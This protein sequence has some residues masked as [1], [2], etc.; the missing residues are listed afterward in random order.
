M[1]QNLDPS[2]FIDNYKVIVIYYLLLLWSSFLF[3]WISFA[4]AFYHNKYNWE[5]N[6]TYPQFSEIMNHCL[7]IQRCYCWKQIVASSCRT[8]TCSL[9]FLKSLKTIVF[10]RPNLTTYSPNFFRLMPREVHKSSS[11][12]ECSGCNITVSWLTEINAI[13][14]FQ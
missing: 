7:G 12:D 9:N 14:W 2:N 1:T 13:P 3:F 4:D 11:V 5:P 10:S 6:H 8:S